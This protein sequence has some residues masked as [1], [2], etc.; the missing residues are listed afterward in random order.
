MTDNKEREELEIKVKQIKD[1]SVQCPM[2]DNSGCYGHQISEDEIEPVQCEN[3]YTNE[4][5]KFNENKR[6]VDYFLHREKEIRADERIKVAEEIIKI[7]E[8]YRD[9]SGFP[10]FRTD[11]VLV[12][13]RKIIT[14]AQLNEK[15]VEG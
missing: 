9:P 8:T 6:I 13:L 2:C 3:C 5:S 12:A 14:N 1:D 7:I 10:L 15:K 4:Y 11:V